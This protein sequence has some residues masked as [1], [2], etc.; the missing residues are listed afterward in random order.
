[1]KVKAKLVLEQAKKAQK[2]SRVSSTL[3]LTSALDRSG[4]STPRS[5]CFTPGAKD[6][7]PIV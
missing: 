1:V 2:G 3:S 5:G 7:V 6:P 4:C